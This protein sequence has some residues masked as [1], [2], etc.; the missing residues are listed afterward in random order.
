[1]THYDQALAT[2]SHSVARESANEA[3]AVSSG[4]RKLPQCVDIA[5]RV[6]STNNILMG[7]SLLRQFA[8]KS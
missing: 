4:N 8:R 5:I 2:Y 7:A 6:L 3:L 1:L